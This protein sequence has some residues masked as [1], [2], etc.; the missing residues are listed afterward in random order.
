M[1]LTTVG[2]LEVFRFDT[3]TAREYLIRFY[4]EGDPAHLKVD[5]LV[6]VTFVDGGSSGRRQP[7]RYAATLGTGGFTGPNGALGLRKSASRFCFF[8]IARAPLRRGSSKSNAGHRQH[9]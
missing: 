2:E 1:G 6:N 7:L 8:G 3:P 9:R 4:A 5:T